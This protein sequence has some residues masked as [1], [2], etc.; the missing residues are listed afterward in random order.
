MMQEWDQGVVVSEEKM[1][2]MRVAT[3]VHVNS[4]RPWRDPEPRGR[5]LIRAQMPDPARVGSH[6]RREGFIGQQPVQY[7]RDRFGRTGIWE[8][9]ALAVDDRVGDSS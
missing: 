8:E 5:G 4:R 3:R 2:W 1:P 6:L 9:T 7:F